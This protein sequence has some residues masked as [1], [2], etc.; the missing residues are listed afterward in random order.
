MDT[1]IGYIYYTKEDAGK[2]VYTTCD[3]CDEKEGDNMNKV[4]LSKGTFNLCEPVIMVTPLHEIKPVPKYFPKR[5]WYWLAHRFVDFY[6]QE[7]Y[8]YY[9]KEGMK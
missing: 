7:T 8:V 6:K 4:I 2:T 1:C 5:L 9:G 3:G